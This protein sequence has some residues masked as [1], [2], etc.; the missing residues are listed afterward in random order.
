MRHGMVYV[1]RL[2]PGWR[3]LEY[4]NN[5]AASHEFRPRLA[6]DATQLGR[7][8]QIVSDLNTNVR[9]LP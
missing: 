4:R 2:F 6:N 7:H 9:G 3:C 1:E 8:E 5:L